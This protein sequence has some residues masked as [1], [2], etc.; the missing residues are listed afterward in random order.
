M[1]LPRA[2]KDPAHFLGRVNYFAQAIGAP[3]KN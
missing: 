1:A 3:R 2:K